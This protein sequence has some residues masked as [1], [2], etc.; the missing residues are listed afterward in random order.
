M[1]FIQK[2]EE[3]NLLKTGHSDQVLT[4]F[5]LLFIMLGEE[6]QSIPLDKLPEKLYNDLFPKYKVDSLSTFINY[7]ETLILNVILKNLDFSKAQIE[8]MI[9]I[10]EENQKLLVS[11]ELLKLNKVVSYT[12]FILKEIYE[13]QTAK[14]PDGEYIYMIRDER[15]NQVELLQKIEE[16]KKIV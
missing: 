15:R 2:E 13:Y 8:A 12:T 9:K 11:S 16:L 7:I 3:I 4:I 10:I 14:L 6:Y 1:N 5:K